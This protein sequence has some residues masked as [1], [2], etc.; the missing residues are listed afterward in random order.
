MSAHPGEPGPRNDERTL[1][2]A[3]N[4]WYGS[5]GFTRLTDGARA[6]DRSLEGARV[7]L[8]VSDITG[9]E[10]FGIRCFDLYRNSL[11]RLRA[12]MV[13]RDA[14]RVVLLGGG[15]AAAIERLGIRMGCPEP[16]AAW[17]GQARPVYVHIDLDSLHPHTYLN[18]KCAVAAGYDLDGLT[19]L[20]RDV[21]RVHRIVGMS[22]AENFET[23]AA[24]VD[25]LIGSIRAGLGEHA[26]AIAI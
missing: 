5:P 23:D 3:S 15:C 6:L 26:G 24:K 8:F 20:L 18:P 11:R 16:A 22:I 7:R 25:A 17:R 12:E 19:K 4:L 10:R 13:R 1:V 21:A 14:R 9:P 2:V